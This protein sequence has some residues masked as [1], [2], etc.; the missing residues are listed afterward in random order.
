VRLAGPPPGLGAASG[1]RLE[2]AAGRA[3]GALGSAAPAP[4]GDGW[5]GLAVVREDADTTV[6]WRLV[7]DGEPPRVGPAEVGVSLR[8]TAAS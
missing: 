8:P 2:D 7:V 1:W 6:G 5:W 4:D 3:I